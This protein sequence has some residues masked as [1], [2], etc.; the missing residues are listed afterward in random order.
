MPAR[1]HKKKSTKMAASGMRAKK[2]SGKIQRIVSK[3]PRH[4]IMY[5]R[6]ASLENGN[7]TSTEIKC[8]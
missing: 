5:W 2:N 8:T 6:R 4:V 7:L 1:K 3:K